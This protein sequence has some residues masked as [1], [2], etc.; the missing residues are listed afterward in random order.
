[1]DNPYDYCRIG[2]SLL[3]RKRRSYKCNGF[4][5]G[6]GDRAIGLIFYS[7]YGRYGDYSIMA[8]LRFDHYSFFYSDD[9]YIVPFYFF[10]SFYLPFWPAL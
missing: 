2:E 8:L 5:S 1:M 6:K 9:F 3:V 7:S 4:C 10:F